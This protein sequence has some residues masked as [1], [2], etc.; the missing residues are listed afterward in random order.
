MAL[1]SADQGIRWQKRLGILILGLTVN[2]AMVLGYD[3][4]VYPFLIVHYGLV[5]GWM[6][7]VEGSI[8]LCLATLMFYDMTKQDWLGIET[9]KTVRDGEAKGK[10]RKFFRILLDRSDMFA[11]FFLSIRYDPFITTVY[12]RRGSSFTMTARDWKIFWAG[13][14]VS[15]LWWGLVVFGAIEAFRKW[16][17]PLLL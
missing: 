15:N 8:V 3:F 17:A 1:N 7:A 16:I 2:E 9:I 13:I 6:L 12:M 4:V 14:V 10:V 5:W 11:F